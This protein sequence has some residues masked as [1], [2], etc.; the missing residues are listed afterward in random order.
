[1]NLKQ[2]LQLLELGDSPDFGA[3]KKA[4]RQKALAYHPDRNPDPKTKEIFLQC[5]EAYNFLIQYPPFIETII[6]PARTV[7]EE[8]VQTVDD[9]FDDIFGFTRDG[10]VLGYEEPQELSLT[11]YE[12]IFGS[13]CKKKLMY[14]YKACKTCLGNGSTTGELASICTYCFGGGRIKAN[15]ELKNVDKLCPR[16]QGRGRHV[17]KPCVSCKGFGRVKMHSLQEIDIPKGLKLNEAYTL[18]SRDV[19]QNTGCQI[20]IKPVLSSSSLFKLHENRLSCTYPINENLVL[21]G[22]TV[23]M[24][25]FDVIV[26]LRV[27]ARLSL[28]DKIFVKTQGLFLD[29]KSNQRD[30]LLVFVHPVSEKELAKEQK[31]FH[32]HL[33]RERKG[34]DK[35]N[36]LYKWGSF[37]KDFFS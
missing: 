9:I 27:P 31:K 30:D 19:K 10:R 23:H 22:G 37:F 24:P 5:T 14:S 32:Q 34:Y 1:L 18:Q 20:F 29:A 8:R 35:K 36:W 17:K 3:V 16:C 2:A 12:F 25:L 7:S 33:Q 11:A 26:S 13:P 4:Y 6:P 28:G 15:I 21:E